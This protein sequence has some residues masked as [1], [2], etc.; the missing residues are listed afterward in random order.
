M[1]VL[2]AVHVK[3]SVP[4]EAISEGED[5][6]VIDAKLCTI[7]EL[8]PINARWKQLYPEKTNNYSAANYNW[9]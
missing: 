6:Y 2:L 5:K 9:E 1:N 4:V 8:V 7:A 3:M